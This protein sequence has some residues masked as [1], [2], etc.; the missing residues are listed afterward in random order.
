MKTIMMT[1]VIFAV[2]LQ[3]QAQ[4]SFTLKQCVEYGLKYH[5]NNTIYAN[6]KTAAD[7]RIKEAVAGYLPQ[8]SVTST[9]DDNLKLQETIIPAGVLGPEEARVAFSKKYS[10]N[11][12]AQIDQVI[13]NQS[14]LTGLKA[15]KYHRKSAELNT[16][17]MQEAVIY[18]VSNAYF[19]ILIYKQQLNLLLSNRDSYQKQIEIFR[20]Q[21]IKGVA[22]NKDLDKVTV[23]YNNTVS[24]IR[25]AESNIS[26]TEN[27]LKYE[28]G[29]P[30]SNEI[31]IDT[32]LVTSIPALV[33]AV[34]NPNSLAS[35]KTDYQISATNIKLLKIEEDRIRHEALPALSGYAL[36]GGIGYGDNVN[37]AYKEYAPFSAI[38]VKLSI[39]VFNFYKRNAQHTQARIERLNAEENLKLDESRYRVEYQNAR[40]KLLQ[41]QVNMESGRRNI[42]LAE[43]TFKVTDLQF[44]KGV[45]NLIDWLNT[46]NSLKEAQNSY[47]KSLYNYLLARLDLERAAGSLHTFYNSL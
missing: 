40:T 17:Q 34:D 36:Y 28:M 13:Y 1:L 39:P 6:N 43:S 3:L 20:L 2:T 5:R 19:Q 37:Q 35:L 25:L 42:T 45:T 47:L 24:Q 23:D 18:N 38:G 27:E 30:I 7:A 12:T 32:T 46:Q 22:L 4:Q 33:P 44:Q 31:F 21:V 16:K 26:L 29:Y 14:L 8:I 11:T 15:N 41:E 10:A 9:L